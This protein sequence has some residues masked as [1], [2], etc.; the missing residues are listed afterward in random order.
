MQKMH[1]KSLLTWSS[2]FLLFAVLFFGIVNAVNAE[3]I[4]DLKATD[5]VNDFAGVLTT[6][7]KLELSK[8]LGDLEKQTKYQVAVAIVNDLDG[9]YIE[10]YATKLFEQWGIGKGGND[11]N[12]NEGVLFLIAIKDRQMRIEVGYGLEAT[13]TDG[14][15]KNILDNFVKPEFKNADYYAGVKTGIDGIAT[16]LNGGVVPVQTESSNKMS[17]NNWFNILIVLLI[18]GINVL[19]WLFAIM[20]RS[21]SWWLGGIICFVI[22]FPILFFLGFSIVKDLILFVFTITGF[23]FDYFVSKNYKY[24][25]SKAASTVGGAAHPA[26]WAGGTWGGGGKNDSGFGGFGGGGMSGGGGSSSSW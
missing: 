2:S 22:G 12:S 23:I 6:E 20:A 17:N 21:K 24:W 8:T 26:W 9:D 19:G 7:Q 3:K 11:K 14:I 10:H 1:L 4:V 5:Y 25:Q 13:L 18:V 16:T 15:S